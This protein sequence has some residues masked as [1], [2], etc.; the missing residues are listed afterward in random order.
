[1]NKTPHVFIAGGDTDFNRG[2]KAILM[3]M[4]QALKQAIPNIQITIPALDPT[5]YSSEFGVEAVPRHDFIKISKALRNADLVL[6]GGGVALQDDTSRVKVPF[7]L[8]RQFWTTKLLRTPVMGIAGGIGPLHSTMGRW[9][10]GKAAN[11]SRLM[12]TRD[13]P[14]ADL[15]VDIG[16]KPEKVRSA[17]CTAMLLNGQDKAAGAAILEK[18]GVPLNH[19]PLVGIATRLWFHHSGGWL[20]HEWSVKLGLSDLEHVPEQF[21]QFSGNLARLA[22]WLVETHN[23][24]VIFYPMYTVSHE[25]D[26]KFSE[27]TRAM[28]QHPENATVLHGEYSIIDF[29]ST[30]LPLDAFVGV[31]MHSTILATIANVPSI[32]LYYVPKGLKYFRMIGQEHRSY[33]IESILQGDLSGIQDNLNDILANPE[34]ARQE[35]ANGVG[36]VQQLAAQNIDYVLEQLRQLGFQV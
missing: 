7:W 16:V 30:F 29:A 25:S 2:D 33:P 9:L 23:A 11:M 8:A 15:L 12:V 3:G 4:V 21:L 34:Q 17:A 19:K 13:Q 1:M 10:S 6:W 35:L 20:P 27:D 22:D 14:A 28:M 5:S 24:H 31:R 32:T 18:E 26:Q 36:K